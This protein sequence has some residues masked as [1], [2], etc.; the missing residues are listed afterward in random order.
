[1]HKF[2]LKSSLASSAAINIQTPAVAMCKIG[3]FLYSTD[4][5]SVLIND[6]PYGINETACGWK[7]I[8]ISP[9]AVTMQL[10][11]QKISYRSGETFS[12]PLPVASDIA[13]V[14]ALVAKGWALENQEK[15]QEALA[16]YNQALQLDPKDFLVH[17][18]L[19][20]HWSREGKYGDGIQELK[21][22][23]ELNPKDA[24]SSYN[25]GLV[26]QWAKQYQNALGSYNQAIALNP[27]YYNAIINRGTVNLILTNYKEAVDDFSNCLAMNPKEADAYMYRGESY[28]GLKDKTSAQADFDKA[29]L[30]KPGLAPEI[31]KAKET[32]L[33]P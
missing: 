5:P 28:L 19:G 4:R 24:S 32:L 31:I 16:L 2:H 8:A 7:I 9:T 17:K 3:G 6:N 20:I 11:D 23:V 25:L 1:M 10:N 14:H 15:D 26:Y 13:A 18:H 29:L 33:S 30:L 12:A 21:L 22:A 27:S